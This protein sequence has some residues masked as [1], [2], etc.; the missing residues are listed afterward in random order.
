[1]PNGD[2]GRRRRLFEESSGTQVGLRAGLVGSAPPAHQLS[3]KGGWEKRRE[4]QE[5][6]PFPLLLEPDQEG[7]E[8]ERSSLALWIAMSLLG[9]AELHTLFCLGVPSLACL[10]ATLFVTSY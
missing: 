6:A 8:A 7:K 3:V 2:L 10:K 4:G 5:G 1:M 9:L